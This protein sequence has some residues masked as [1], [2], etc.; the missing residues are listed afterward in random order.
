[1]L[2]D[3][4]REYSRMAL[5]QVAFGE[6]LDIFTILQS[7]GV[8]LSIAVCWLVRFVAKR[9]NSRASHPYWRLV[10]VAAD[11]T[12]IF[13]GLY[14]LSV[15]MDQ[16]IRGLGAASTLQQHAF[17]LLSPRTGAWAAGDFV[18]VEFRPVPLGDQLQALFCYA[19]LPMVWLVMAAV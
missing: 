3:T 19:L 9:L 18:P 6:R 8:V 4:V 10:V 17:D 5:A 14:A 16:S 2:G 13:I 12:W 1:F 7:G 11:A 15:W